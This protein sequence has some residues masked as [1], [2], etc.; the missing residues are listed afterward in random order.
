MFIHEAK[1]NKRKVLF[2][3]L[4]IIF[5]QMPNSYNNLNLYQQRITKFLEYSDR[6][7]GNIICVLLYPPSEA[8]YSQNVLNKLTKSTTLLEV[9]LQSF[10][11]LVLEH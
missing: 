4:C 9:Y 10:L 8:Y 2:Y 5:F 1:L 11:V 7:M 3:E 6:V